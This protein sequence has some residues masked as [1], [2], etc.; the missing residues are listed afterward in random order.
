[1][2]DISFIELIKSFEKMKNLLLIL[3]ISILLISCEKEDCSCGVITN[4]EILENNCYSLTIRNDCSANKK[5]FCFDFDVWFNNS[6]G[7]DFCVTN[8]DSW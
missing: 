4:D 6:V 7:D 3:L 8:E 2:L 5:T 1:M